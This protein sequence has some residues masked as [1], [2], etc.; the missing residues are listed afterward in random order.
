MS[1]VI[2]LQSKPIRMIV[3]FETAHAG[4]AAKILN[5]MQLVLKSHD[6]AFVDCEEP[7][8]E[9]DALAVILDVPSKKF[10]AFCS[11]MEY[12][13]N[14]SVGCFV[15]GDKVAGAG[16]GKSESDVDWD[17]WE[18]FCQRGPRPCQQI[19]NALRDHMRRVI[20]ADGKF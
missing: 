8:G 3:Y 12:V 6:C 9:E 20:E 15:I 2:Q 13:S 16:Q 7:R 4:K 10:E 17:V 19:R 5:E 11:V 1:D 18:Y 14:V